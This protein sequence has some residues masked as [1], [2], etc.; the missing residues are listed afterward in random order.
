MRELSA[1]Q[2]D[3]LTEIINMGVGEAASCLNDI[4]GSHI[5][6]RVPRVELMRVEEISRVAQELE[7]ED[8]A[9]VMQSFR[10]DFEGSATLIFPPKSAAKLVSAVTG[11]REASPDLD[12]VRRGTLMEIGNIVINAIVGTM[13]NVLTC[14]LSYTLPE[15][16]Q[17][18]A[19]SLFSRVASR[20]QAAFVLL[21]QTD[22]TIEN[23]EIKG[24]VLI[25][26]ELSSVE[27]FLSKIAAY[28][29][30]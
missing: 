21:V 10:G 17:G 14:L 6:L 29:G 30:E 12:A 11:E 23:L 7:T 16:Y 5:V 18:D 25:I 26:L 20:E 9:S 19:A 28:A 8:V 27:K 24:F 13:S 2:T 15:Y 4:V 22:F 3:A 1:L